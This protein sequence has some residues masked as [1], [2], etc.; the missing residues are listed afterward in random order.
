MLVHSF[1]ARDASFGD[2]QGFAAAMG[3]P[4]RSVNEV[5]GERE[6]DGIRVRLAWV[7]DQP[8][9]RVEGSDE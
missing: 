7:K 3:I 8:R 2:F 1:S 5:S 4:V 6:C 9:G